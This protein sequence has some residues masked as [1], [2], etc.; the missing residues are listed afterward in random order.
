MGKSGYF[1][2]FSMAAMDALKKIPL[3]IIIILFLLTVL[4][5]LPEKALGNEDIGN[6]LIR[7]YYPEEYKAHFQ[8]WATVQDSRGVMYFGNS[9]GVMI[10]NGN[11][12][13]LVEIAGHSRVRSLC[14]TTCGRV[15]VSGVNEI[16]YLAINAAGQFTYVSLVNLVPENERNFAEVW[17]IFSVDSGV[18]F[19]SE[20]KVFRLFENKITVIPVLSK[21][22]GLYRVHGEIISAQNTT[23]LFVLRQGRFQQLPQCER[24]TRSNSGTILV[25]PYGDNKLLLC[26][27]KEGFFLYHLQTAL[28]RKVKT[29]PVP[30]LLEPFPSEVAGL[31]RP[32]PYLRAARIGETHYVISLWGKGI[33]IMDNQGELVQFIDE[34]KGLAGNYVS[35]V[36]VDRNR[37]LW[38]MAHN[39]ISFIETGSPLSLFNDAHGLP[40]LMVT[41]C[42][43]GGTLYAG[44][45]SGVYSL[46]DITKKNGA[47]DRWFLPVEGVRDQCFA[48]YSRDDLLLAGGEGV[49]QVNGLSGKK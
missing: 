34:E 15:F 49:I 1:K 38:V 11:H 18:Y 27:Q 41:V 23:G 35:C 31:V 45:L 33:C 8:N 28:S 44:G 17:S 16:G 4:F 29:A 26:T 2:T 46:Q 22:E 36:F 12:W 43:H 6:P 48:L 39:G 14:I 30:S 47:A 40:R 3:F 5:Y 25:L 21:A 7:N 24:F 19:G 10:Y 20:K 9:E 32:S 42:R 37:N 13:E